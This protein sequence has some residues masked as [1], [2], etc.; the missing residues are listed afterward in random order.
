MSVTVRFY[1]TRL[2]VTLVNRGWCGRTWIKG[3]LP[4]SIY[5]GENYHKCNGTRVCSVFVSSI[6]RASIN[7]TVVER[8]PDYNCHHWGLQPSSNVLN[9]GLL[10]G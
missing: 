2:D 7:L 1:K 10:S 8:C 3:W 9:F 6:V 4:V 5:F